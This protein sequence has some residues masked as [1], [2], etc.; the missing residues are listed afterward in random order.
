M[1]KWHESDVGVIPGHWDCRYIG[2]VADVTKLA[3]Y[4]YTK[5]IIYVENG[6][7]IALR[8]LNVREGKLD[9]SDIKRINKNVSDNLPRSK[10]YKNDILFTYVGA[11][12]GQFALIPEDEIFHL[13]PNICRIRCGG[14]CDPYFVYSYFR[15]NFF[16]DSLEGFSHGS[17]Q[18]TLPMK[19]I[20]KIPVPLPPLPEQ[21]A[22]VAILSSL[23]DKIDLLYRQSKTLETMA[24]T[25][26]RQWFIEEPQD[27]WESQPLSSVANFLNGLAC[28]KYPPENNQECLPVLKIKELSS[29][30][31]ESSDWATSN[32]KPEYIV[33]TG[34]V[35]FAWSASLMVKVWGGERCILNQH[36]FKVTSAEFPKWF[37]L[38]WCKHHLAEFISISSSHATTMGHIKRG[39][40]DAA[41]TLIP[42]PDE[43]TEMSKIMVP[44]LNKKIAIAKQRKSLEKLRDT[45][46]PKLMNGEIKVQY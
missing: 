32:V 31:S 7:V 28:Q 8:A 30:M 27:N 22:I 17:S 42:S 5:H 41:M 14:E 40:L 34:D 1:S 16:R 6:E 12:I 18:P 21:K 15:T 33:E 3:G 44:L 29:G 35:I 20:R 39:D 19:N 2:D 4:E 36:L 13:A 26:F 38:M 46:L 25:L 24:E 37:Y 11:N 23:D 10:L 9:L 43:L 45:L